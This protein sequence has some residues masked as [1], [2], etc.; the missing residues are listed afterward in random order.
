MPQIEA[1]EINLAV[2]L[3]ALTIV[4]FAMLVMVVDM[5]TSDT[6]RGPEAAIPWVALVGVVASMATGWWL[7]GQ[8]VQTFQ[9][10][11]TSD[12]F[13][14]GLNMIVL[15]ATALGIFLSVN[16]IPQITKQIGE[17]YSLLLLAAAGMMMMGS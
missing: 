8:P 17:Y 3:P 5:F 15:V 2:L 9:G 1:L 7:F 16:Y 12:A 11:A 13:A 4:G 14:L 6:N 10:M